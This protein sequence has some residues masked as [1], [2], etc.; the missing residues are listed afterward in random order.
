MFGRLHQLRRHSLI[1]AGAFRL[2]RSWSPSAFSFAGTLSLRLASRST[3]C[4][5]HGAGRPADTEF[6]LYTVDNWATALTTVSLY[7]MVRA[8][9]RAKWVWWIVFGVALGLAV[10]TR[11]NLAPWPSSPSSLP[12]SGSVAQYTQLGRIACTGRPQTGTQ[13]AAFV[14]VAA[15]T[16]MITF[17][18]AMPYA[19]G[20][21]GNDDVGYVIGRNAHIHPYYPTHHRPQSTMGSPISLK[22]AVSKRPP[23]PCRTVNNGSAARRCSI[24]LTQMALYGMGLTAAFAAWLAFSGQRGAPSPKAQLAHTPHSGILDR[25]LFPV[26]GARAGC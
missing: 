25:R 2:A 11:I 13:A 22:S 15:I 8:S 16:A 17:R 14:L 1:R 7:A 26:H 24:P 21:I 6:A 23:Q 9:R 10:A 19:F 18:L 5:T 12:S 3:G 4:I 20:T